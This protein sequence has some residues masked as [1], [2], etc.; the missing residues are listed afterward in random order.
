MIVEILQSPVINRYNQETRLALLC[1]YLSNTKIGTLGIIIRA[2][3]NSQ[4]DMH[5]HFYGLKMNL[6]F[7]IHANNGRNK[8]GDLIFLSLSWRWILNVFFFPIFLC[9]FFLFLF[10]KENPIKN[11]IRRANKIYNNFETSVERKQ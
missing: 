9:S 1:A 5:I 6:I 4:W 2:W 11:Y 3:L 8:S 10:F 7:L